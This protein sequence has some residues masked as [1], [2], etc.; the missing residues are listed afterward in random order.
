MKHKK[1]DEYPTRDLY[2]AAFLFAS[3]KNLIRQDRDNSCYWFVFKE[4]GYCEYL[5]D[6]YWSKKAKIDAKTYADSIRSLKDR[7]FTLNRRRDVYIEEEKK[8]PIVCN[9]K[10]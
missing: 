9:D 6:L 7:I 5:V 2:E 8:R 1:N 3:N 4:D 10:A